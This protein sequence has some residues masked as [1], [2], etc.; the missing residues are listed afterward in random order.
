MRL[1]IGQRQRRTPGTAKHHPA[2]DTKL[3]AQF[4]D[5]RH[6]LPSGVIAQLGVRSGLPATAL[7]E[8]HDAIALRVEK[9]P[10]HR[11]A[12]GPWPTVQEQHR[13]ALR[14]AAFLDV[15]GMQIV[16]GVQG[17][18]IVHGKPL[19]GVWFDVGKERAHGNSGVGA[20]GVEVEPAAGGFYAQSA[21]TRHPTSAG[22][23]FQFASTSAQS[24]GGRGSAPMLEMWRQRVRR[25]LF[26]SSLK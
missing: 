24:T 17:M 9:P 21:R 16:H 26:G 22:R 11:L 14:A 1:G 4:L 5:V 6:Q 10:V 15:Q 12:T 13:Q 19:G 3:F 2:V 7:V 25:R 20:E 23:A 18:Q 8:Q